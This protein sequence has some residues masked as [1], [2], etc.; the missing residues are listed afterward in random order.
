MDK[1]RKLVNQHRDILAYIFF[2]VLT[3]LVNYLIYFPVHRWAQLGAGVSNV[4]AWFGAVIFAFVTNKAFVFKDRDWSAGAVWTQCGK[5]LGSRVFSGLLETGWIALTVD[6]FC[7]NSI[8]MKI[9][10]SLVVIV[11]NFITSRWL[12]FRHGQAEL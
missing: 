11:V 8:T 12:V 1:L 10:A 6:I 9:L 4:I 2:G 5:F 7:W 3:T